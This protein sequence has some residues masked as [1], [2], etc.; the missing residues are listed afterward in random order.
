M[1]DTHGAGPRAGKPTR[2]TIRGSRSRSAGPA[3]RTGG[4]EPANTSARRAAAGGGAAPRPASGVKQTTRAKGIPVAG[5][6]A[7]RLPEKDAARAPAA[8]PRAAGKHGTGAKRGG[9]AKR[10]PGARGRATSKRTTAIPER[11]V[12][13]RRETRGKRVPRPPEAE[14]RGEVVELAREMATHA[15]TSPVLTGGDVDADW[16]RAH[17]SGEEAVGGS[18]ATPDQDIVDEIGR[19]LGVEQAPDAEVRTSAEILRGRDRLRW[20]LERKA[21]DEDER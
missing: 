15:E 5:R 13:P 4:T 2:A 12:P 16:T 11:K 3:G 7:A 18:V 19:A 1:K 20:H 14:D 9:S 17:L 8:K 6:A 10:E 21:A